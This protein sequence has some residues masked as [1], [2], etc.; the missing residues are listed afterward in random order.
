VALWNAYARTF[1]HLGNDPRIGQ[2]LV[3]LLYE[4]GAH[5]VRNTYVF[6]GSCAGH[7]HFHLYIE[8]LI[9]VLEGARSLILGADLLDR[10]GYDAGINVLRAWMK[11]PDAAL[12]FAIAW[13]EGKR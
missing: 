3:A 6:F 12:W 10:T 9:G 7:P 2:R 5:P 13:A 4:A 11:R 1:I 8:N